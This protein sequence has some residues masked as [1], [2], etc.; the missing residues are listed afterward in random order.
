[1]S[2]FGRSSPTAGPF[3]LRGRGF[4]PPQVERLVALRQRVQDGEF[5]ELTEPQIR[6]LFA[7]WLVEHGRLSEWPPEHRDVESAA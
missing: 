4:T 3:G 2:D 5:Y 7:R 6:L 1:M